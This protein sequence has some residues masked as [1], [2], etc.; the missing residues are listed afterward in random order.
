MMSAPTTDKLGDNQQHARHNYRTGVT[1]GVFAAI[2]RDFLHPQLILAGLVYTLTKSPILVALITILNKAFTMGPQL[3]VSSFLEHSPRRRPQFVVLTFVRVGA[4]ILLLMAIWLMTVYENSSTLLLFFVVYSLACLSS[5][6]AHVVYMDMIGRLI[7]PARTGSY[8]GM[9]SFLGGAAAIGIG[10]FVIQPILGEVN[11]PLNYILLAVLGTVFVALD[12]GTWCR[13]REEP[14][15]KASN[16]STFRDS[17]RRG[18][19][20]LK[21]D[22]NYRCYLLQRIGFR[23]SFVGLAF[24]I[25]YGSEELVSDARPGGIA[26]LGGIMVAVMKLS[27]TCGG[28]FWGRVADGFGSRLA[29]I[30]GGAFFALAPATALLAPRL[31]Q[32]FSLAIPGGVLDLPLLVFLGALAMMGLAIQATMV[33][34]QRFLIINA[35]LH[36]RA[37][38]IGFL[39]TLTSPLTLLPLA[40][41]YIAE[42]WGMQPLF[43]CVIAGGLISLSGA[44]AMRRQ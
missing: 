39:N 2:G 16:R 3:L 35:P 17:M 18:L 29:L 26:L 15:A 42:Y 24:F 11:L 5:A 7:P 28:L 4:Y 10:F 22:H 36:R 32:T 31:P 6:C 23:V 8:I 27:R 13:C 44:L 9:R 12:M 37:S 20:W 38:Y 40:G 1:A 33:A 19:K 30:F 43:F 25:P 14:G 34:G 41:A 21:R